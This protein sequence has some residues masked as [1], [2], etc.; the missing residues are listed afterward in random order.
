[1]MKDVLVDQAVSCAARS[2][3]VEPIEIAMGHGRRKL[4]EV[5]FPRVV[6]ALS[7]GPK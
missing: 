1:M 7:K 6:E 3:M 2:S 5:P 4:I